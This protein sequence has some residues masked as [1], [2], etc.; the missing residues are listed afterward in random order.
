MNEDGMQ[1]KN[2]A[3]RGA[4]SLDYVLTQLGMEKETDEK[5]MEWATE[6]SLYGKGEL[7]CNLVMLAN[8]LTNKVKKH[9]PKQ[10]NVKLYTGLKDTKTYEELANMTL[11]SIDPSKQKKKIDQI[12]KLNVI[13]ES[14]SLDELKEGDVGIG[15]FVKTETSALTHVM[16]PI[17]YLLN[18]WNQQKINHINYYM[19]IK[20]TKDGI[21]VFD[22]Y[23]DDHKPYQ[24]SN[25]EVVT[26]N[27]YA[28]NG[29]AM[30]VSK[31]RV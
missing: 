25:N 19:M 7:E 21:F 23:R 31:E 4:K 10:Y 22:P 20:K 15:V 24:V 30:I 26:D 11:Q 2:Q 16:N 5:I 29:T 28:F 1:F 3:L 14:Y 17:E 27:R 18:I 9:F 13:H 8:K 12:N 6:M